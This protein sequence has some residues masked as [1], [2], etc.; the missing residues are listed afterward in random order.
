MKCPVLSVPLWNGAVSAQRPPVHRDPTGRPDWLRW[1]AQQRVHKHTD[2]RQGGAIRMPRWVLEERSVQVLLHVVPICRQGGC[3]CPERRARSVE[4]GPGAP[5]LIGDGIVDAPTL[6]AAAPAEGL[7][8]ASVLQELRSGT[9]TG[10]G[11]GGRQARSGGCD[12]VREPRHCQER[13]QP[14]DTLCRQKPGEPDTIHRRVRGR[15]SA[16]QTGVEEG[17]PGQGESGVWWRWE[18]CQIPGVEQADTA[19]GTGMRQRS[20]VPHLSR[21]PD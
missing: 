1:A 2:W 9:Q 21:C 5:G 10:V 11:R 13:G 12:R 17:S 4:L 19:G 14:Q 16:Q 18:Q 20:R 6:A 8:T 15:E 3:T 7:G